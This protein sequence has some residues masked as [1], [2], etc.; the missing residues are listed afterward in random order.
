MISCGIDHQLQSVMIT[1]TLSQCTKNLLAVC[2]TD[3]TSVEN[4]EWVWPT[5]HSNLHVSNGKLN[6][7]MI[8]ALVPTSLCIAMGSYQSI[9]SVV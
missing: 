7:G 5:C 9:L 2:I 6:L 4:M 1:N 3:K 8:S